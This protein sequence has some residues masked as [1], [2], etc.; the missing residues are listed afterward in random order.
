MAMS[1]AVLA[2][3]G[4][5]GTPDAG[6]NSVMGKLTPTDLSTIRGAN[7][8]GAGA[9]NTTHYW[10]NYSAAETERDLTYADRLKLNQLR[11][12]V[13]YASWQ[14]DKPAFRRNLIDLARACGRHR[15]GLMITLGDTAT[16]INEGGTVTYRI[17]LQVSFKYEAEEDSSPMTGL[18]E[19]P[20]G[21]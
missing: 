17:K 7:Y 16:F 2:L 10:L 21:R 5:V 11:V 13:N 8:R 15:I 20:A 14:A 4:C 12:F 18:R 9:T 1:L 19:D 6:V 3:T